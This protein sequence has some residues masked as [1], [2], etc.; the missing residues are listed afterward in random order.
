MSIICRVIMVAGCLILHPP[1]AFLLRCL[2]HILP[3]MMW[4]YIHSTQWKKQVAEGISGQGLMQ[5]KT[6]QNNMPYW[7][8]KKTFLVQNPV[9]HIGPPDASGRFMSRAWRLQLS[10][11]VVPSSWYPEACCI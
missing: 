4:H 2:L 8:E 3:P 11:A 1:P 7:I 9:F 10:S 6:C 5:C